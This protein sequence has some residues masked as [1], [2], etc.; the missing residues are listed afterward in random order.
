MA[1]EIITRPFDLIIFT[2]SPDKGKLVAKAASYNLVPCILELGGKNPT[3]VDQDANLDVAIISH[4]L[5]LLLCD[6]FRVGF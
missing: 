6:L 3:I 2:G 5:R 1:V 4:I